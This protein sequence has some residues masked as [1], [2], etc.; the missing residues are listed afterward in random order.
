MKKA[1]LD[2]AETKRK[3]QQLN[4]ES[5]KVVTVD[6]MFGNIISIL[7][8]NCFV[9]HLTL[10]ISLYLLHNYL[11]SYFSETLLYL[12]DFVTRRMHS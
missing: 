11:L 4:W 3:L 1:L 5:Q 6:T 9:F 7:L 10:F 2:P 12:Y 8:L